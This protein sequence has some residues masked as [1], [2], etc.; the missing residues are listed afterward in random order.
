MA[1]KAMNTGWH[2]NC[3]CTTGSTRT[4]RGTTHYRAVL[5]GLILALLVG[6]LDVLASLRLPPPVL[7]PEQYSSPSG[8]YV[9]TVRPN[10]IYGRGTGLY[11]LEK[12][13]VEVWSGEKAYT[14]W[15]AAVTDNGVV[16]GYAYSHGWRGFAK[17][18][19]IEAGMGDMIAAIFENDGALRMERFY[20]RTMS[21]YLHAAPAPLVPGLIMDPEHDRIILRVRDADLN[22]QHEHWWIYRLSDGEKRKALKPHTLFDSHDLGRVVAARRLEGTPFILAQFAM[23]ESAHLG[24][25]FAL[26]EPPE[27]V[28]WSIALPRDHG[29]FRERTSEPIVDYIR[30]HSAIL[31]TAPKQFT[32]LFAEDGE[33]VNFIVQRHERDAW[34]VDEQDRSPFSPPS[35]PA[36]QKEDRAFPPLKLEHL[37]EVMLASE[38][39]PGEFSLRHVQAYDFDEEGNIAIYRPTDSKALLIS[40]QGA[41]LHELDLDLPVT[42]RGEF[43]MTRAGE[44]FI[45]AQSAYGTGVVAELRRIHFERGTVHPI[46]AD[47]PA[48]RAL[49]AWPDGRLAA[50]TSR[51]L[52]NSSLPGL[53]I[54]SAE[55][56]TEWSNERHGRRRQPDALLSPRDITL[57]HEGNLVVLDA[58]RHTLQFFQPDGRFLRTVDLR[59]Q[60]SE[61]PRYPTRVLHTPPEGFIVYQSQ[62]PS[63]V[64]HVA[65]DGSIRRAL[66]LRYPNERPFFRRLLPLA[67]D[68]ALWGYDLEAILRFDEEGVVSHT[69]GHKHD[70]QQLVR[71]GPIT[72]NR[73][74]RTYVMDT[75][76]HF[77]HVFDADGKQQDVYQPDP[78][79]FPRLRAVYL[80]ASDDGEFFLSSL[81]ARDPR[82]HFSPDGRQHEPASDLTDDTGEVWRFF[83]PNGHR[84]WIRGRNDAYLAS[85][86]EGVIRTLSRRPDGKWLERVS[87]LAMSPDGGVAIFS[88]PLRRSSSSDM[89]VSLYDREG[90]P[91]GLVLLHERPRSL[92][93]TG[94]QVLLLYADEILVYDNDG[95]PVGRMDLSTY[96]D[97]DWRSLWLIDEG[98]EL[99]VY[100][101]ETQT[102]QRFRI[103]PLDEV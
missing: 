6:C 47:I 2:D 90:E 68:G 51:R 98:R 59:E 81:S 46:I 21:S 78:L 8:R 74:G 102:F 16:A 44:D 69:I 27:R 9:L 5:F 62:A 101:A 11:Q 36:A 91:M 97:R 66:A 13:G 34:T 7:Q 17:S 84:L 76:T 77:I 67:P 4:T 33:Q 31:D 38:P 10:D 15:D 37:G 87:D 72:V 25:F 42:N 14:L 93:W 20:P 94:A 86:E 58:S 65:S 53:Y 48:V 96:G 49:A 64:V 12:D 75:H 41:L 92:A 22:R 1:N 71:A 89:A 57:D 50:L 18:G 35:E 28:V 60:W 43:A 99:R 39:T 54:L 88:T 26:I 95:D 63:N 79:Q 83:Q 85:R 61:R 30:R 80:A 23:Q 40:Q 3:A 19:G 29:T 100:D 55:G 52:R 103:A 82:L 24:A 70:E 56:E 45:I 32:L 73:S